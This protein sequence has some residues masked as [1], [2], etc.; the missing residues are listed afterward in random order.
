MSHQIQAADGRYRRIP[1]AM[2]TTDEAPIVSYQRCCGTLPAS[3]RTNRAIPAAPVARYA[4]HVGSP[5]IHELTRDRL[6]VARLSG[7]VATDAMAR[8]YQSEMTKPPDL[9]TA[10]FARAPGAP[11]GSI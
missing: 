8:E 5:P 7:T 6:I 3:R 2:A 11:G 1:T 9:P 4:I 10:S